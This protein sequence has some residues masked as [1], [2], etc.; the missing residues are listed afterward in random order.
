[1]LEGAEI[2]PGVY[3][4]P[5]WVPDSLERQTDCGGDQLGKP[6][7]AKHETKVMPERARLP[8]NHANSDFVLVDWGEELNPTFGLALKLDASEKLNNEVSGRRVRRILFCGAVLANSFARFLGLGS[9]AHRLS[10]FR[11]HGV[12]LIRLPRF[13][14]DSGL[15]GRSHSMNLIFKSLPFS[16]TTQRA[17]LL[18][19]NSQC[20][21]S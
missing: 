14:H 5:R 6:E 18:H 19:T 12:D 13:Q 21:Q 17:G 20:P 15:K 11:L 3:N 8:E 2:L 4:F 1:M 16:R 9:F 10:P 7:M